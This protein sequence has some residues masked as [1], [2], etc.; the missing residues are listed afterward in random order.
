MRLAP[1]ARFPGPLQGARRSPAPLWHPNLDTHQ[2]FT[3]PQVQA[4]FV[5]DAESAA[6]VFSVQKADIN[7][8]NFAVV[9]YAH[10]APFEDSSEIEC[11]NR[12][13]NG[14]SLAFH[15]DRGNLFN[16]VVL[17]L[18]LAVVLKIEPVDK[19]PMLCP[20]AGTTFYSFQD[21][22]LAGLVQR[23][24]RLPVL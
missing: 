13:H 9:T 1:R 23:T 17:A 14:F 11:V 16:G 8:V 18:P 24:A 3:R 4:D 21:F 15:N 12:D 2:F 10:P 5:A 20:L 19:P 22:S 6:L 7:C